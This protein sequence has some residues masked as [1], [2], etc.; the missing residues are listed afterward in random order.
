MHIITTGQDLNISY[1]IIGGED[2]SIDDLQKLDV[3]VFTTDPNIE[4]Q[5]HKADI[6]GDILPIGW[7]ILSDLEAGQISLKFEWSFEDENYSDD[8]YDTGCVK[9]LD[10]YLVKYDVSTNI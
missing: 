1:N 2:F 7:D 10:Y 8:T 5:F 6:D 3:T 9:H 4:P